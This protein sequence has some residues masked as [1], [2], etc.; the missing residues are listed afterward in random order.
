MISAPTRT[1]RM[2][3]WLALVTFLGATA[4][5]AGGYWD[6]AWHTERGRDEFF[7]APHIAIYAGVAVAGGALTLWALLTARSDGARAVWS[8]K[9][10]VLAVL[11]VSVTL[12]S[13]PIDNAWHLA[14]GRDAVIWSP[15]HMLGIA[16]TLALGA[17]MLA[18]FGSRPERWAQAPAVVAGALVLAAAAFT[19]V[20]YDTDVPQFDEAFYLPVLGFASCIAMVLVR[21]ALRLR[22]A[23]T[24]AAGVQL[25][26]IVAVGGLLEGLGFSP[27]ALPL[28]LPAA[29]VVDVATRRGWSPLVTA[30]AFTI[31]LHAT[32]VPVRNLLGD[33][34]AFDLSDVIHGG[35]ITFLVT[36]AVFALANARSTPGL[37]AS[38]GAIQA[39]ALLG[40]AIL[41]VS[42]AVV[43]AARAH[44]PGQGEPAGT[45]DLRIVA[46]GHRVELAA[47]LSSRD[48]APTEPVAVVARRAGE[49]V[50]RDLEKR[51]CELRGAI[52]VPGRGRWFIY[53][54]MRRSGRPVESWLPVIVGSDRVVV[55]EPKRY[56]YFPPQG[57]AAVL[58]VVIGIALYAAML[59][60]L[61]ATYRLIA[62]TQGMPG[63]RA[64]G[65]PAPP[66]LSSSG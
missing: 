24:L 49:T 19:T 27:S 13:G 12:A 11:G 20:E 64:S 29:L 51:G 17:A 63:P 57:E 36:F 47:V 10:L 62:A 45:I 2:P 22:W 48:C 31:A 7:I 9:P 23:C 30:A 21:T 32:Y 58:E 41:G 28:L 44:D 38:G 26:F 5:L 40:T 4:A 54:E 53:A 60:L 55:A 34:V 16:G 50:R 1:V 43:P 61:Y 18:E 66:V 65:S 59:S 46:D 14:F 37:H 52:T 15:P 35:A 42:F 3:V 8:H 39:A 25:A 56:A 6:D 33:G